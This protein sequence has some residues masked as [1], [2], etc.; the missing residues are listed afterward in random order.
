MYREGYF[1]KISDLMHHNVYASLLKSH[2][3]LEENVIISQSVV[4]NRY[5]TS[6]PPRFP[7]A[8]VIAIV[9]IHINF[10]VYYYMNNLL[11]TY[12]DPFRLIPKEYF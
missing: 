12:S 9:F 10:E 7:L 5:S 2:I 1:Y 11:L 3:T 4:C 6:N 8:P